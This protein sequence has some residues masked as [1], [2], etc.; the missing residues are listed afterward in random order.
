METLEKQ[1][2]GKDTLELSSEESQKLREKIKEQ[3][4]LSK[5][6]DDILKDVEKKNPEM[7]D[8]SDPI[9]RQA[10]EEMVKQAM[11]EIEEEARLEDEKARAQWEKEEEKEEDGVAA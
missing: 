11:E 6:I 2:V 5:P 7:F 8:R 3:A 9:Q 4:F 10:A 1:K